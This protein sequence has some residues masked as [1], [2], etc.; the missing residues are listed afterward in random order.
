MALAGQA[1]QLEHPALAAGAD[2]DRHRG[3]AGRVFFRQRIPLAARLALALPAIIRRAA[4][5]AD[6]G[7][8]GFG[9]GASPVM[10]MR[11]GAL[12]CASSRVQPRCADFFFVLK[13][14]KELYQFG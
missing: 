2:R 8:G 6:K 1:F 5:L 9:H 13:L 11:C 14:R 4:V 7:E 10:G 3:R 12:V